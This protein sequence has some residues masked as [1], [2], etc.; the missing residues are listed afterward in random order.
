MPGLLLLL[1]LGFFAAMMFACAVGFKFMESH[2]K[3]RVERLLKTVSSAGLV[4]EDR[5]EPIQD[6]TLKPTALSSLVTRFGFL[7]KLDLAISGAAL[8]WRVEGVLYAMGGMALVGGFLGSRFNLLV[9]PWVSILGAALVFGLSPVWYINHK[10]TARM[11][12]FERQFPEALDFIARSVRAGHA[13]SISLELLANDAEAP[14]GPEFRR[15]TNELNLGAP[16]DVAIRNLTDR[17]PLVDV[18]FFVSAILLQRETGGNLTEILTNLSTLI[19][20]RFR[21]KGHVKAIASQG[22]ITALVLTVLPIALA[23][24]LTLMS[25]SYLKG[26]AADPVG[27]YLILG[28]I[29]GQIFGYV[30]MQRIVKIKV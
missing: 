3:L 21:L 2:Q 23:I 25:P 18:R 15:L 5:T 22:K 13:L 17:V 26:M 28:A 24:G 30:I 27:R 16:F 12:A 8:G 29:L 10:R 19:R 14:V 4:V 1:F 7:R 20:S 11:A 6:L 9:F